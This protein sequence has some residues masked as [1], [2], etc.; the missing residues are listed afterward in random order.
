MLSMKA[1][2]MES[3]SASLLVLLLKAFNIR[4]LPQWR[5]ATFDISDLLENRAWCIVPY[6]IS[7][8][9]EHLDDI[10]ENVI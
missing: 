2:N 8:S 6:D 5:V 3:E 1:I 9:P 10:R 4:M 7:S